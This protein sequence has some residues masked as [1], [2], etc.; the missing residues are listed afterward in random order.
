VI[1]QLAAAA[2]L[3]RDKD[4]RVPGAV[5]SG[6]GHLVTD[7]DGPGAHVLQRPADDDLFR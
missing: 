3:A 7:A 6:I 4:S 1:D 5:V 2:D